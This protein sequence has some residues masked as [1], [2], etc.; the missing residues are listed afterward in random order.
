[1]NM[2]KITIFNLFLIIALTTSCSD[3]LSE[4]PDN[5]TTLDS[6]EKV[7]ELLV[8]AYPLA[9]YY[10]IAETRS[11]NVGDRQ[12][13]S[14]ANQLNT[15]LYTWQV[16]IDDGTDTPT[17]YWTECYKAIAQAN[18]ALKAV[19]EM[20]DGSVEWEALRGEALLCRA[21]AHFMLVNFWGEHYNPQTA[22]TDL[23]V[24]YVMEPE[25]VLLKEYKRNTVEEVYD[26]VENDML[27][28]MELVKASDYDQPVYHFT[29]IAA[30]A[31][32]TR[33]YTYKGEWDKVIDYANMALADNAET[34]IR[35]VVYNSSLET[36]TALARYTSDADPANILLT[37]ANSTY[38]DF[39][40]LIRTYRFGLT[41]DLVDELFEEV[42]NP[43]NKPWAWGIFGTSPGFFVLK[44]DEY[45]KVTNE[46]AQ[47]GFPFTR[48]VLFSYDEILLARAEAYA[49]KNE[50]SN[51]LADLNIYLPKKTENYNPN[52][53]VLTEDD[54]VAQFP[55]I[56]DEFQP[57]YKDEM[58][59]QQFS[60]IKGIAEMRRREYYSEGLRWFDIKRYHLEVEHNIL[61]GS[62]NKLEAFDNRRLLQIPIS[63]IAQGIEENPR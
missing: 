14:N 11:D 50:F 24:P 17:F 4:T 15:N 31:L 30:Y 39:R 55:Y 63:A 59:P 28:G 9:S 19:E 29:K 21:Y 49:M 5:R 34:K 46:S 54:M 47:I 61:N 1:M 13:V 53:D 51:S 57:Y 26:M 32:A 27:E 41:P 33:F 10:Y 44:L 7:S 35:D 48:N 12:N 60:F 43:Y 52:T 22:S 42:P 18:Y 45:F 36:F 37:D 8:L 23:G 6:A 62:N 58:S 25:T 40:P 20:G 56:Q 38:N 3:Y 2:K 16:P